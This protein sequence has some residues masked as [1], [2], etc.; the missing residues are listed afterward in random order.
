MKRIK[1]AGM[2]WIIIFM[3]GF[4]KSVQAADSQA[5]DIIK[6]TT[7]VMNNVKVIG[8][9]VIVGETTLMEMRA[10]KNTNITYMSMSDGNESIK[11]W[12]DQKN[13]M[14][15]I[16]SQGK[17][18]FQPL[19]DGD[20]KAGDDVSVGIDS[21]LSFSY[22]G[23]EQYRNIQC[24]KLQAIQ[25]DAVPCIYYIE[26]NTY[27]IIAVIIEGK[28]NVVTSYYFYPE[29]V[30][31]PEE[32]KQKA[33]LAEGYCVTKNKI[34]YQCQY[35]KGKPVLYAVSAKE[36]K[37]A[38]KIAD[39]VKI[40]GQQYQVYGIDDNAFRGNKKITSA[41][42]GKNVRSIGKNAF[43]GCKKLKTVRI[44]SSKLTK[45]GAKAFYGNAKKLK[46]KVPKK[47]ASKYKKLINKSKTKSKV[48][49]SQ[50]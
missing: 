6:R 23:E 39:C 17:Y 27:R 21:T 28:D 7:E 47:K 4:C 44:N 8:V 20:L 42:V 1:R 38:L 11:M 40:C 16:Y 35:V 50:I 15:Y 13:K 12:M 2:L 31:V 34:T 49:Y 22:M 37:G 36:A 46:F 10:D 48:T 30:T 32:A 25:K 19:S 18:Y 43:Y 24:Y 29:S 9:D 26:K 5:D 33:T 14:M 45:I 3:L 41:V